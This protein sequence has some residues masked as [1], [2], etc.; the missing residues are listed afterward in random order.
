[1]SIRTDFPHPITE[2]E[3]LWIPLS[4][5]ARLSARLWM[6][7]GAE[8]RP[9]PALLEYLPYRKDDGTAI[10]DALRQP[11][12]AGHGYA[13]VRVDMRG[14]GNSDGILYDEYL[15]QEQD[16]ALE[17]LRW[18]ASQPWCDGNIGMHGIS[19]GG[20]NSLQVA[21]RRPPELKA[22]LVI[23][24]TDDRYHDDVHYMGGCVLASQMLQWASAMF[25]YN[26][27]PPDPRF[28][29]ARWRE[30]WLERM[31]KTPPYIETWLAHQRRDA[32][33]KHGSV[34]E[35]YAAIQVPV[36]AVGGWADSY[37]NSIPRLLAGLSAP[38]RGLIGP[39]THAFP[40]LGPPQ[41]AIGFLQESLRWWDYWLKG[42]DT[43]I[44]D[45]P[46]LRSWIQKS[47]PP[48]RH[49][50]ARTGYWVSEPAWPSPNVSERT[51]YLNASDSTPALAP[52]PSAERPV[53]VTG[54]LTHGFDH[55]SWG[56]YGRPG[57][58]PGDQRAADGEA[59]SFTSQPLDAPLV[60][61]GN[62]QVDLELAVDQPRAL[63]AVRLCDVAPEGA[64][65]LVS[66]GLLN[67]THRASHEFPSPLEP[68][69]RER[70]AVRLNLAG[71]EF[72][73][74]H[75]IRVSISPTYA[76]QAWPSPKTPR[77]TLF[78]GAG[79]RLTLPVRAPQETDGKIAFPPP[80]SSP[81]LPLATLR[82]PARKQT[83]THDHVRAAL[84][85]TIE[86][87][88]GRVRFPNGMEVDERST[89]THTLREGDPLSMEQRVQNR[90]EYRREGWRVRL[91][92]DSKLTAD[93]EYFYI[94]NLLEGYEG[95]TRVFTKSWTA[96]I[97]RDQG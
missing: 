41:P 26:A 54:L 78:T 69:K 2:I 32:Y 8:S 12:L 71:Y 94:N 79:C 95:E 17:I 72:P 7:D 90:L 14:S 59:L 77:L 87:D 9:V 64:S 52:S 11:Y 49:Y 45:E 55:V 22:V 4:D 33:W 68:G 23:G 73:Q 60:I 47:E 48:A 51:Y 66:W 93:A 36:F 28:T 75:R 96:K 42:L 91:E 19:W 56:S 25:V 6:P 31:D 37:N 20:F 43:G 97:R 88:D 34:G 30:M 63:L 58:Y 13:A 67:L 61:L 84:T 40:E 86:Q 3:N 74:G 29:G 81:P 15:K 57:E 18:I 1:M 5:G 16:D 53:T 24:F 27:A 70:V 83:V 50:T 10:R 92:T 44:M 85:L 82:Q 21:A 89:Q 38:C 39:W 80:E 62:P 65:A 76:S 46:V 35:D